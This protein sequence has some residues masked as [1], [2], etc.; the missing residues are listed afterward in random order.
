MT[1]NEIMIDLIIAG[2]VGAG[3]LVGISTFLQLI[4]SSVGDKILILASALF[5]GVGMGILWPL[6]LIMIY[7]VSVWEER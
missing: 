2:Y 4:K 7:R 1:V 3:L 6:Y 5:M